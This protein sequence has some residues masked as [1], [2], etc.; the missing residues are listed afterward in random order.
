VTLSE[1]AELRREREALARSC[2]LEF[3]FVGGEA[4]HLPHDE[5][6]PVATT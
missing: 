3:T 6:L 4:T 1:L 5:S 2:D